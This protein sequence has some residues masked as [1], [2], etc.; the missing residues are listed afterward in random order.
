MIEIAMPPNLACDSSDYISGPTVLTDITLPSCPTSLLHPYSP[1]PFPTE[2]HP[3]Q[4][5]CSVL[6]VVP[7]FWTVCQGCKACLLVGH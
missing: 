6:L 4:V 5:Q 2:S 7:D 3:P 1:D